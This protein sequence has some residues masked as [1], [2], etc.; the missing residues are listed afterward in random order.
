MTR[1]TGVS[2]REELLASVC[3]HFLTYSRTCPACGVRCRIT[4]L[5]RSNRIH[6]PFNLQGSFHPVLR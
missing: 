3:C 4:S 2:A 1:E 5:P 6:R